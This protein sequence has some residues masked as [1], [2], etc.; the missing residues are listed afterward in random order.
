ME[1]EPQHGRRLVGLLSKILVPRERST[2]CENT[3]DA[4]LTPIWCIRKNI[5]LL[6]FD[7][8]LVSQMGRV[9]C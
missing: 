3:G 5:D 8:Q 9:N 1:I 4:L 2:V 6:H 7:H